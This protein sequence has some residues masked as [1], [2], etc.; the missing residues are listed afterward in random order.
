MARAPL[1]D[2]PGHYVAP[3]VFEGV[4]RN[5][6]LARE[7]IFGPVLCLFRAEDFEEALEVALDS[8]FA[9]TGGLYS[10]HPRHIAR[11]VDAFRVGNLYVNRKVTGAVVGRQPFGGM[12]MSGG[13]DKAGG[14]EYL[15]Q[16]VTPRVVTENTVRRGFAPERGA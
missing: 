11:A 6:R 1:P 16:F 8:D 12:G 9:L 15:L 5:S 4:G 13:G 14:P 7:E 10:R 3:H 2:L